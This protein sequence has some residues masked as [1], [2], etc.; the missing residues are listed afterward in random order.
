[1]DKDKLEE[2]PGM[3]PPSGVIPN[4]LNPP[5]MQNVN[6]LCQIT[7]LS[8]ST[9]CVVIRMYTKIVIDRSPGWEDCTPEYPLK[10][11]LA[12]ADLRQILVSSHG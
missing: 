3:K 12:L 8:V 1:M 5:T 6:L 10:A 7:C 2:L 4:L 9:I 11:V